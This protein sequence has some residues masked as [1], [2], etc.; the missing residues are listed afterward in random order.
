MTRFTFSIRAR[1]TLFVM[2]FV[3]IVIGLAVS[4]V[5]GLRSVDLTT[6]EID[7]KW[8]AATAVLAEIADRISEYRITEGYRALALGPTDRAEAELLADAHRREIQNLQN[9]YSS[10]LGSDT[11]NAELRSFRAAWRAYYTEHDA[12]VKADADGTLDD[13]ARSNSS[14]QQSYKAA[15]VAADRLIAANMSAVHMQAKAVDRLTG[16]SLNIAVAISAVS[17]LLAMWLLVRIR[18]QITH[19]LQAITQALSQLAAGSRDIRVPEVQR[20]DEIGAM[21]KAFEVFRTNALALEQAHEATRMAQNQAHSLARHDALTGLPNR[22]VFSAHLQSL[23]GRAQDGAASYSVLLVGLDQFKQVNDLQGRQVGDMVLCEIARRLKEIVGNSGP[24]ARLGGDE[25]AIIAAEDSKQQTHRDGARNLATSVLGAIKKPILVG[26]RSLEISAS[27]GIAPCQADSTNAENLLQAADIAMYRAKRD[28]RGIVRLFEQSMDDD[29]RAKGSL[30]AD[31]KRAVIEEQIKPYYQPLVEIRN[32][33]ICGFEALARW[34]H[35]K[36]G[37][38]PP[39]LFIPVVE[40][41]GLMTDLTSSVLR[42]VCRD[43]KHWPQDI[44]LSV[45]ISPSELKDPLLPSRLLAILAQ[46]SFSPA[47][48]EVEITETALVSDIGMAKSILT[49]LQSSGIKVCLDDFGTGYSSLYH[50]RELQFDKVKIDRSFVQSM[51][52]NPESEKIVDA[53]LGLTKNLNLP[54]VA[55]GIE[56]LAVLLQ[57]AA[58]GCEF[59]QGYYFGKAMTAESA[60]DMLIERTIIQKRITQAQRAA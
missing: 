55:E 48:L 19:P 47:R 15:D 13:P 54:T 49:T 4:G 32:N 25:F 26:E 52:N 46:E 51:R 18:T 39:D 11:P 3:I 42:Q 28:G 2:A 41:L 57:L 1:L 59:G 16:E 6:K 33:R 21:A 9:K 34:E 44:R 10:L 56:D 24:V 38:V 40:Q 8:F 29:L 22:R 31:I 30:E 35:P 7:Q 12:W 43:A 37:F 50:L 14:L 20:S 53:I 58:K 17:L 45:N 60:K 27:I 36:R 23:L 5:L